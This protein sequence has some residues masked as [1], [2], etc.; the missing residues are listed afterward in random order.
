MSLS[1]FD[2]SHDF[3]VQ[4]YN[5]RRATWKASEK[6]QKQEEKLGCERTK[7]ARDAAPQQVRKGWSLKRLG[8]RTQYPAKDA[9]PVAFDGGFESD[10]MSLTEA[11][12]WK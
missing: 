9:G 12:E 8:G 10:E 1:G 3:E 7:V 11:L 6:A 2:I 5:L 4:E